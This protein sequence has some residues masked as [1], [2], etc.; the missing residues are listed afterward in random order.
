M[1]ILKNKVAIVTGASKGIGA[2]IAKALGSAGASVVVNY[3]TSRAGADAVVDEIVR[4][5][6][7]AIAVQADVSKL[8]DVRRLFGETKR[9]FGRLD[10]LVNNA[11]IFE[12]APLEAVD[13]PHFTRQFD[14]NVL[15]PLLAT[16]EALGYFGGEGGSVINVSSVVSS[17]PVEGAL[18]YAATKSALD[19]VTRVLSREL[20]ARNVR[21]NS[22]NPGVTNTEG[23]RAAQFIGSPAEQALIT[24]TPLGRTALPDDIAPAVVFLASD[25]ARWVTGESI[26][27]SGGLR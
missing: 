22:V 17:N 3:A 18:V 5:D 15:G 24:N 27:V 8:E 2:G 14:T 26:R 23:A 16:R 6:G 25:A 9:A 21:V 13:V 7:R 12:F 20:G 4:A 11:G 10:V 1:S 19:S